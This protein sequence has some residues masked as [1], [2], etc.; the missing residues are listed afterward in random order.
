[1][2]LWIAEREVVELLDLDEA[3][4]ALEGTLRL[5]A[6]G[7]ARELAKT[8]ASWEEGTLH[9]LGAA[10]PSEGLAGTK[11][12]AHTPRGATPLLVL[13][14]SRDGGLLAIIEA[15]ALGQLRT[16]AASGVATRYLADRTAAELALVGTGKQAVPQAAAVRAVRP[17]RRVRLFGR[18]GAR[19]RACAAELAHRFDVEVVECSDVASAVAGAPIVTLATRATEPIL[20]GAMLAPGAHVNAIGAIGPNGAELSADVVARAARLVVDSLAQARHLSREL[21]AALGDDEA[22][23][24]RVE[25]LAQVVAAGE[26]RERATSGWTVFKSFGTGLSDLALGRE[27]YRRAVAKG[28]GRPIPHPERVAPRLARAHEPLGA[29]RPDAGGSGR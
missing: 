15:F 26:W 28:L 7:G 17:I 5:D 12:W 18:D 24:R 10:L 20:T 6:A 1:M 2:P 8:H 14:D 23:W 25:P 19:R 9:A 29:L 3:I 21:R 22:A 4:G 16:A 27:V 11:T 13:F